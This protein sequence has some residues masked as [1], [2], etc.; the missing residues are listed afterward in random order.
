M[1]I[2]VTGSGLTSMVMFPS[3]LIPEGTTGSNLKAYLSSLSSSFGFNE[4]PHNFLLNFIPVGIEET[5]H[6]A[7]GQLP[8]IGTELSLS[9]GD[10][11]IKGY[12]THSEYG[13]TNG[14][15][16]VSINMEDKRRMLRQTKITTDDLGSSRP[17]GIVSIPAELRELYDFNANQSRDPITWEYR[18]ILE[19]GATYSEIYIALSNAYS[20]DKSI[21]SHLQL[22]SPDIIAANMGGSDA[23]A[24]RFKFDM[25]TLDDVMSQIMKDSA[26]DWYWNMN[27]DTVSVVNRKQAFSISEGTLFNNLSNSEYTNLRFGNDAVN[28]PS[29]VRLLGA[30][31]QGFWNS[32]ILSPI[33]GINLPENDVTFYPA[34]HN[35]TV[36]FVDFNG[37]L[38]SY[39]PHDLELQMALAG[40][41]QWS[42]YKLYQ[43]ASSSSDPPGFEMSAD[44]GSIA[45][46]H[47]EFQSRFD[48]TMPLSEWMAN[49]SGNIRQINNRR[50]AQQN[51][52]LQFYNRVDDLAQRHFGRSYVASGLLYNQS[53]GLIQVVNSAWANIENQIEGQ[54][55]SIVGA[56]GPFIA[57]Y[58]INKTL[59]P[60][61]PFMQKDF[62]VSAHTVLPSS[63]LYGSDGEDVPA[64]FMAWSEDVEPYN[65]SGTGKH[66]IPVQLSEVG[67][68]ILD[69]RNTEDRYAFQ[70]Y[71]DGTIWCQFPTIIAESRASGTVLDTLTTV[72]ESVNN[73]TASGEID[74]LS[75]TL[76]IK[77]YSSITGV[78]IPVEL[79]QRYGD[80]Y[81]DTWISGTI[82][83][84][85][86]EHVAIDDSFAPWNFF[87]VGNQGSIQIMDAYAKRRL[88]GIYIDAT[89][90]RYAELT[91]VDF[92]KTSFD[93]FA[94]QSGVN[95]EYGIRDHGIAS[96]S[97]SYGVGGITTTYRINDFFPKT[98]R[99][100][101]LGDRDFPAFMAPV[102]PIDFDIFDFNASPFRTTPV[103]SN[104]KYRMESESIHK[105]VVIN[106]VNNVL[107][108]TIGDST[109]V[110][111]EYYF[112]QT[113][114]GEVFP[115]KHNRD[116]DG[117]LM[118]DGAECQ[119]GFLDHGDPAT[120]HYEK[121]GKTIGNNVRYYYFTGG[122]A[123]TLKVVEVTEET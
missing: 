102:H 86:G 4:S 89:Q 52:V 25:T 62:R 85:M 61:S 47:P 13:V 24:V 49:P 15:T 68:K 70:E 48:P 112:G 58:Q 98:T 104:I 69:P 67:Q 63:T 99:E 9:V 114:Q 79:R 46:Q 121:M 60:L 30:R 8:S 115:N 77:P 97:L 36:Q 50:D 21:I 117:R 111:P 105:K 88:E 42:Y 72:I 27:K 2:T 107:D 75:P 106:E 118:T 55:L 32:D 29:R 76:L 28:E 19:N 78:A 34:W 120:Y 45:A 95:G 44:N 101:P 84:R 87:P 41:E 64:S 103:K 14:G 123:L 122:H 40:I 82:H 22:P 108:I 10:F 38:R 7:S 100:S 59:G 66:Y 109:G 65:P 81:P 113:E 35:L 31:M 96:L 26:Y 37:Q 71:P 93:S 80:G 74:F 6:G 57:G 11:L 91:Q 73:S 39:K 54:N 83:P 92:P 110:S 56:R 18:K 17:S 1:N 16:V 3:G 43:T 5:I 116:F 119:D 20:D 33:D 23:A 51:W 94:I 90:S 53:S 12:V